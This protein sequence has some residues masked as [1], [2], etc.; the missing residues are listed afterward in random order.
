MLL[1]VALGLKKLIVFGSTQ[2]RSAAAFLMNVS[3]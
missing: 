2:R 1:V 3:A